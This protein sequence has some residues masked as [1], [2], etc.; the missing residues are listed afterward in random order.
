MEWMGRRLR[1]IDG[2]GEIKEWATAMSALNVVLKEIDIKGSADNWR[3]WQKSKEVAREDLRTTGSQCWEDTLTSKKAMGTE[4]N[5]RWK[6]PFLAKECPPR[7]QVEE[8]DEDMFDPKVA[9]MEM[10]EKAK[11]GEEPAPK[12]ETVIDSIEW[13][14]EANEQTTNEKVEL[15]DGEI[16]SLWKEELHRRMKVEGLNFGCVWKWK[17]KEWLTDM[18]LLKK[19]AR[20]IDRDVEK[21]IERK[22][23]N[24]KSFLDTEINRYFKTGAFAP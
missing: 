2:A 5:E 17:R 15:N 14:G 3:P 23:C 11:I 24:L 13:D 22:D 16:R 7:V 18:K 1:Y 4:T 12:E 21:D 6:K 8:D 10:L 20:A 19:M 9:V